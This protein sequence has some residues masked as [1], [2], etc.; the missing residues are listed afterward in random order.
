MMESVRGISPPAAAAAP[1]LDIGTPTKFKHNVNV[2]MAPD[3]TFTG[4]EGLPDEMLKVSTV[5]VIHSVF[6]FL[7][8]FL[9]KVLVSTLVAVV[10]QRPVEHLKISLQ[11]ITTE[12]ILHSVGDQ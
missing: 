4:I 10:A 9:S 5:L 7:F 6:M 8:S 3:G 2:K 11:N 1:P 12:C